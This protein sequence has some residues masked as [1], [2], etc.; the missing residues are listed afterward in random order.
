MYAG[1]HTLCFAMHFISTELEATWW[2][3]WEDHLSR[4]LRPARQYSETV[5]INKNKN[6]EEGRQ[7]LCYVG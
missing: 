4:S 3:K 1:A 5:S 7:M 6:F 2:L